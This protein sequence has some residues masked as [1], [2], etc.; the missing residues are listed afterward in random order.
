MPVLADMQRGA[1]MMPK[2]QILRSRIPPGGHIASTRNRLFSTGRT[3]FDMQK[4]LLYT[5]LGPGHLSVENKTIPDP[6]ASDILVKLHAVGI[7]PVDWKIPAFGLFFKKFPVILGTCS[8]GVVQRVGSSVTNYKAGDRVFY[9]GSLGQWDRAAFQQYALVADD[10]VSKIPTNL[11]FEEAATIPSTSVTAL[12]ALFDSSGLQLQAPFDGATP[13]PPKSPKI[14]IPGASSSVGQ[15]A[16]QFARLAGLSEIVVT[17]SPR[18]TEY[19]KS[20]GATHVFDR[21]TEPKKLEE[22]I[23]KVIGDDLIYA[24]DP[25][26][27]AE[28]QALSWSLLSDRLPGALITT[29]SPIGK[30]KAPK[31]PEGTRWN[32]I[33]GSPSKR[34]VTVPYWRNVRRWA[35]EGKIRPNNVALIAGGLNGIPKALDILQK[36]VSAEKLVVKPV[37]T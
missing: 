21:F 25:I 5:A 19:L 15:F 37:D 24:F 32:I 2:R 7:N 1:A 17:A 28:T 34:E 36:G 30:D 31:K 3:N 10:L 18:H 13:P 14:F 27:V 9:Q 11:S 8:A 29:Q 20:L 4:A 35:E 26:S 22:D 23:R 33:Q 6:D 12:V 16:I